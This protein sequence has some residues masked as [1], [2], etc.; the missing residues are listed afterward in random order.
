MPH[1][2]SDADVKLE[3]SQ[4]AFCHL[5]VSRRFATC[6]CHQLQSVA[7]LLPLEKDRLSRALRVARVLR[8][9]VSACA[10]FNVISILHCGCFALQRLD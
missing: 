1:H 4:F 8:V 5:G 3:D 6:A 7:A 2:A 10:S 9:F